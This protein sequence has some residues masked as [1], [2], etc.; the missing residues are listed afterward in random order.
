VRARSIAGAAISAAA[1]GSKPRQ[2]TTYA[3][4][5]SRSV[6]TITPRG[7]DTIWNANGSARPLTRM[8][9]PTTVAGV[10]LVRST[11]TSWVSTSIGI[12]AHATRSLWP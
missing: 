9:S 11:Y 10:V 12:I 2:P 5:R 6:D 8:R 1:P 7:V 3:S 4:P